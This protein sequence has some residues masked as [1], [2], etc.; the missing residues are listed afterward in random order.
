MEHVHKL[1]IVHLDMKP[2]N[3]FIKKS[4]SGELI[5]KIGDFGLARQ[6]PVV[7]IK[8]LNKCWYLYKLFIYQININN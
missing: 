5:L 6:C 2:A 4:T 3:I 7:N 1:N 8:Y